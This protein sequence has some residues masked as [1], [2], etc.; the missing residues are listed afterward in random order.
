MLRSLVLLVLSAAVGRADTLG[1]LAAKA[2]GDKRKPGIGLVV[3]VLRDGKSTVRGF[4][5]VATPRP[6]QVPGH[7]ADGEPTD[8]RD[9]A[10]LE[11]C[12]ALRSTADDLLKYAAANLGEADTPL[13]TSLADARTPRRDS[14]GSSRIG[15][16]WVTMKLPKSEVEIVR[17]NG[18]TGGFRSM[19]LVCP[20]HKFAVVVLCNAEFGKRI[21]RLAIDL[22]VSFLPAK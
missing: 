13:K 19:L 1:D 18:G 6:D 17:H 7:D 4:G 5:K 12:G 8:F 20:E 11:S 15:L 21:D 10:A 9:F 14:S 16:F 2:L 3:G 22:A